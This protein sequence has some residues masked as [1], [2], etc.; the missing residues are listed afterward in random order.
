MFLVCDRGVDSH[1][2]KN[3]VAKILLVLYFFRGVI[4][5]DNPLLSRLF[6]RSLFK[7]VSLLLLSPIRFY[8][9]K[10]LAAKSPLYSPTSLFPNEISAHFHGG[11]EGE[12]N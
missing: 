9:P 2:T 12:V 6:G 11:G 4:R 10:F 7:I 3:A 1:G 5:R 8:P